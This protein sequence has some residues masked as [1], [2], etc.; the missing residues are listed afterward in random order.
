MRRAIAAVMLLVL[1]AQAPDRCMPAVMSLS[2]EGNS[3][4]AVLDMHG[5]WHVYSWQGLTWIGLHAPEEKARCIA[6]QLLLGG[7]RVRSD[8]A[9]T[10]CKAEDWGHVMRIV[11]A[12]PIIRACGAVPSC[13]VGDTCS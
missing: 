1:C 13:S 6:R 8:N 5:Q 12:D 11:G 3:D 2:G 7:S 9:E 4:V 10:Q